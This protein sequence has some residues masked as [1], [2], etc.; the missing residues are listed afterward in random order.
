MNKTRLKEARAKSGLTQKEIAKKAGI[1][2]RV[3]QIYESGERIPRANV[4][5]KIAK[6]VESTVEKLFG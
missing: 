6:T 1:T 4:A 5:V 3:Y 2:T